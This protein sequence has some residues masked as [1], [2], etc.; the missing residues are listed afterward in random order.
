MTGRVLVAA[1]LSCVAGV[2]LAAH[3][4]W[5]GFETAPTVFT[6]RVQSLTIANPHTLIDLK[7]ADGQRYRIVFMASSALMRVFRGGPAEMAQQI[8]VNEDILISGRLKRGE[9]V[10]EV[11]ALQIDDAF[12]KPIYPTDRPPI[13]RPQP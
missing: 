3:H 13:T 11:L 9:D 6:A 8:R 4:S 10:I 5:A 1:L 7:A 12:G 2:P